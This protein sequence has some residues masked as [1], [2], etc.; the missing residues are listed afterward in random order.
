MPADVC[1]FI[2]GMG[3]PVTNMS[4]G[5]I[6]RE[7]CRPKRHK[8][9]SRLKNQGGAIHLSLLVSAVLVGRKELLL[10]LIMVKL[11]R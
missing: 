2:R 3:G 6:K 9:R 4:A 5:W 10:M 11:V 1:F 7:C 8:R